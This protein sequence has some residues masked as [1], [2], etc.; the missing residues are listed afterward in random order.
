M[1][2]RKGKKGK[3]VSRKTFPEGSQETKK[4]NET[5]DGTNVTKEKSSNE[6]T[7]ELEKEAV[8]SYQSE[9]DFA[10]LI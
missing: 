4:A 10:S 7:K 5:R 2:K 6:E 3:N 8:L 1:E 9:K